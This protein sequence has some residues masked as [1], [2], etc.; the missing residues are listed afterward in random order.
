MRKKKQTADP[1]KRKDQM[2][3]QKK[4]IKERLDHI[5]NKILV[6]SGKGGVGK[7]SVAAYLSV[8]LSKKGF[9][10][11]LMDVDLHG[12]SIPRILGLKGSVSPG[13]VK[14]KARPVEYLPNMHV[15]SIEV[16]VGDKD[17][18]TIWRGPLKGGVIRQFIA[19]IEWMDLDYMIIDSPPGTGDEPLTVAQT[20][21]DAKALIVT[22]PQEISLADVRKSINFCRQAKMEILGLVENMSGLKCPYCGKIIDIFKTKGGMLTAKK[23]NLRLLG[24]LPMDPEIVE[25]G[26]AGDLSLLDNQELPITREF[27]KIVDEIVRITETHS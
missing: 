16:L 14:G 22:T 3:V 21:S 5:K 2:E 8:A 26:D 12:P 25:R 20:I 24:T 18:A 27:N 19:D 7:S 9:A 1:K 6:M 15:I 17:A 4:E 23:E 11:G 10:V 13:H